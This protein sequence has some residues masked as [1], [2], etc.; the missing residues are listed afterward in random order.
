M[1][2]ILNLEEKIYFLTFAKP[3]YK[4]QISKMIYGKEVKQIYP[5]FN[6]LKKK[7]IINEITIPIEQ[8]DKSDDDGK[9]LGRAKARKYLEANPGLFF[10]EFCKQ[11]EEKTQSIL[12]QK[13]KN[14][15]KRFIYSD[16]FKS[17]VEDFLNNNDLEQIDGV[18][19]YL[20]EMIG[21]HSL[22][23][24]II[25]EY[26]LRKLDIDIT[27][28]KAIEE[29][30]RIVKK[31]ASSNLRFTLEYDRLGFHLLKKLTC[32]DPLAEFHSWYFLN[33]IKTVEKIEKTNNKKNKK[34]ENS[35]NGHGLS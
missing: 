16:T 24:F 31:T 2:K 13:E 18:W 20:K 7:Q 30:E 3:R 5:V 9:A 27:D 32:L 33:T 29:G 19:H 10:E 6:K 35:S 12:T 8:Q 25:L 23:Y 22:Y 1:D 4:S 26:T 34:S 11:L 15:L 28:K 17:H 14:K 21:F